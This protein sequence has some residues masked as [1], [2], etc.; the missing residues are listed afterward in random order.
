MRFEVVTND[1]SGC[2]CGS[3]VCLVRCV[4][5]DAIFS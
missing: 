3:A 4:N 5:R 1:R 2:L